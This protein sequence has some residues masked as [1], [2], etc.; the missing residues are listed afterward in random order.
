MP[1]SNPVLAVIPARYASVRFPGKPL[2]DIDG[3]PMIQHVWERVSQVSAITRVIIA[4]DDDRIFSTASTFG[5]EAMMTDANHASGTDRIWE[6]ARELTDYTMILNVQGDEPFLD[7]RHLTQIITLAQ[8]TPADL[9]TLVT[10]IQSQHEF[11]NPNAVKAV[12]ADNGRA[13]YFSRSPVPYVRDG[14]QNITWQGAYRHLGLYLYRRDCLKRFV[15]L[16]PSKL[17]MTEKLEQL[18]A[19]EAG[20]TIWAAV[21]EHAPM[22]IDTPEDLAHVLASL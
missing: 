11:E 16:P 21:V 8:N 20:M 5:A 3:K 10:P 7:Q 12:L 13:L 1:S 19:L 15:S 22:G 9:Y 14:E 18:R 17:E 4:T 2:V 6:V